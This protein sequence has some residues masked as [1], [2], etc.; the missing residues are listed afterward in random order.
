MSGAGGGRGSTVRD[1]WTHLRLASADR[2][3]RVPGAR[4]PEPMV[5][6]DPAEVGRFSEGGATLPAMRSVYD[7]NARALSALTP[8]GGRVLDLG[9]GSGHALAYF[10]RGRPDA[11]AVG[12]DLSAGMLDEARI[13]LARQG[14]ADRAQ[15]VRADITDLP[16]QICAEGADAVSALW[17]LHQLPDEDVVAAALKQI[18]GLRAGHGSAV[19][20]LDFQRLASPAVFPALLDATDPDYPGPLRQDAIRSGRAALTDEELYRLLQSAGLGDARRRTSS[21]LRML[22]AAWLPAVP[23][24]H[25][26]PGRWIAPGADDETRRRAALI[27]R[28]FGS[29]AARPYP[30][31]LPRRA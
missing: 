27:Q 17:T 13:V 4:V 26:R 7:F 24:P 1:V 23:G 28:A 6:D 16:E 5:V 12:V 20:L 2:R 15:L 10:L 22:H 18:A 30:R 19:W 11:T 9:V 8:E 21:P 29:S 31:D 14:V 25:R 3:T